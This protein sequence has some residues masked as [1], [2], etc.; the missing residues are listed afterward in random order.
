MKD[1]FGDP[2]ILLSAS[3][4]MGG[5]VLQSKEIHRVDVSTNINRCERFDMCEWR[6][7]SPLC[8][9]STTPS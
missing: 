2:Q 3:R 9:E 6:G 7:R 8:A 5:D 4:A 1:E